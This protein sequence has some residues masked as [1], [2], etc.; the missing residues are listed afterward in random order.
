MTERQ[1]VPLWKFWPVPICAVI[2]GYELYEANAQQREVDPFLIV[3]PAAAILL[4]IIIRGLMR[5]K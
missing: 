5:V 2:I 3:I 1:R 4:V